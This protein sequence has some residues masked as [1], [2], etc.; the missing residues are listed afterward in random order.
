MQPAAAPTKAAVSRAEL[1]EIMSEANGQAG[2]RV[3]KE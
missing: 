3:T 2:E 1:I